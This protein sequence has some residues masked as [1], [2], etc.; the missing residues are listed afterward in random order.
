M[1]RA[2]SFT[3]AFMLVISLTSGMI[4]KVSAANWSEQYLQNLVNRK[5]MQGDKYGNL[6][7]DRSITRAEFAALLNRAFGFTAKGSKSFKD[8]PATSWYAADIS[9]ASNQGYMQGNSSGANPKGYLTREEAATMLCRALRI[10]S[11]DGE[12]FKLLDERYFSNWSRGYINAAVDRD[13]V[14]GYP[15][16]SFKPKNSIT[17]GEAAK[18]LS[19]VAGE[20]V[21]STSNHANRTVYGNLTISSSGVTLSNVTVQGDLYV[22]EGVGLGYVNLNNVSVQGEVVVSGAGESNVGQSSITM[23]DC[24]IPKLTVDVAKRKILTLKT[25]GTTTIEDTMIKSST[26]LEELNTYYNG[27]DKV[28]VNGPSG[29]FLN[30]KGKFG[31]V[32]LLS[33][34]STLNLYKGQA[35]GITIDEAA[36]KAKVFLEKDTVASAMYFDTGATVTGTGNIE[37]VL[38]NNDGTTIAQM[39]D[40]IYI[41][42]GVTATI[43]GTKMSS[44]DAEIGALSPEFSSGYPKADLIQPANFTEYYMTNK[45]GKVYYA[46]YARGS[47]RP[48]SDQLMAKSGPPKDAV[49]YGTLNTLPDKEVTVAVSGLKTGT[50]YVVYSLFVDL[51]GKLSDVER[52]YVETEDNIVPV[53]L[54]G[55]PKLSSVDK[56][57][58]MISL[59]PNKNTSYYWA[60][61]PKQSVAP[62]VD[63]LYQQNLSGALSKGV[64]SSGIMNVTKDIDTSNG[65]SNLLQES[66]NYTFYLVLRDFSGNMSKSAYK[67]DFTTKDLTPPSFYPEDTASEITYPKA[68]VVTTT[69]IPFDYMVNEPCTVYWLAAKTGTNILPLAN[70]G[71][72]DLISQKS[73]DT[74]KNGTGS[75]KSGKASASAAKTKYSISVSGLEQQVPYDVYFML[76]DKNGNVSNIKMV[77]AKTKDTVAPTASVSSAQEINGNFSVDRPI[78]LSFS[79]IVCGT[80]TDASGNYIELSKLFASS[81]TSLRNYIRLMDITQVPETMVNIDWSKVTVKDV[82]AKTVIT[83]GEGALPLSNNNSYRFDLGYLSGYV[84]RD[85]SKNEMRSNTALPFK[86]VPPLSYFTEVKNIDSTAFDTAFLIRPDAQ[87]TG[88]NIYFDVM[89]R[90]DYRIEFKLYKSETGFSK[91]DFQ[92][93]GDTFSLEANYA[94]P[95]SSYVDKATYESLKPTYYALKLTKIGSMSIEDGKVPLTATV[96]LKMNAVIGNL[97][98]LSAL[99]GDAAT[100]DSRLKDAVSSGDISSVTAPADPFSLRIGLVDTVPPTAAPASFTA[101]DTQVLMKIKPDK[102]CD[103]YYLAMPTSEAAS[104]TVTESSIRTTK[105]NST[106]GIAAGSF[107]VPADS[108]VA[109]EYTISGLIPPPT[110]GGTKDYVIYYFLKGAAPNIEKIYEGV[111]KTVEVASPKM[112]ELRY[113]PEIRSLKITTQWDSDCTVFYV[114]YPKG[115]FASDPSADQIMNPSKGPE[116]IASGSFNVKKDTSFSTFITSSTG[117]EYTSKYSFY[118]IAQKYIGTPPTPAGLPS[119]VAKLLTMSPKD[120]D[121]PTI[122]GGEASYTTPT[123]TMVDGSPRFSGTVGVTFSE[124][125]YYFEQGNPTAI[126]LTASYFVSSL[127]GTFAKSYPPSQNNFTED[128]IELLDANGNPIPDQSDSGYKTEN[129]LRSISLNYKDITSGTTIEFAKTIGDRALNYAG[130]LKLTFHTDPAAPNDPSKATWTAQFIP[131]KP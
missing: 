128:K 29:T 78:T 85:T 18:M 79:E 113:S 72:P 123:V 17:R 74:I 86:T 12:D 48:S 4:P 37:S 96:N 88:A 3:L 9:I 115:T 117:L 10:P 27:F 91:S 50:E 97:S 64:S 94:T 14:N 119:E 24:T 76:E 32:K 104:S 1:R 61:F 116:L 92:Q 69:A 34:D 15:D 60:V 33:P 19:E 26:Y 54:S 107:H 57:R 95:F 6:Y 102:E 112:K 20:I 100:F 73:K 65:G 80:D 5:V 49:K 122:A 126:N 87:K 42:P 98:K 67:L 62:T 21:S 36:T 70:D 83:F 127:T 118:A 2:F 77:S 105:S 53:L 82:D 90:S 75:A 38:I 16:G 89:L 59:T 30:L 68:G 35:N 11:I 71:K 13:F 46:V 84:I 39:P 111:F 8:V 43:N 120:T 28:T 110:G 131:A 103:V 45:P 99:R 106:R 22:T 52:N 66:L 44:L 58:A 7:P 109:T 125:L 55:Y 121:P 47:S 56:D 93:V 40:H 130:T 108:S 81:N 63:Q 101:G 25:D 129:C 23:T 31:D 114:V 51:R 41:R 124:A